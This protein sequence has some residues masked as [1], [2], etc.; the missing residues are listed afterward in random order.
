MDL[1]ARARNVYTVRTG[2]FFF[3]FCMDVEI[4]FLTQITKTP[5]GIWRSVFVCVNVCVTVCLTM[6]VYMCTC[7]GGC[8]VRSEPHHHPT[9]YPPLRPRPKSLLGPEPPATML[10]RKVSVA[11]EGEV[12]DV[13]CVFVGVC[14]F[15]FAAITG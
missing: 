15:S 8:A 14:V 12:G 9:P 6:C 4:F 5:S 7:W 11:G 3:L 1:Y 10:P 13:W 2:Y